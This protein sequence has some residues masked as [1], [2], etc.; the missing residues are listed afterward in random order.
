M[1]KFFSAVVALLLC[2]SP[3]FS[4][5]IGGQTTVPLYK[6]ARLWAVDLP[7]KSVCFWGISPKAS[8]DVIKEIKGKL[9]FTG[10]A[11]DYTVTLSAVWIDTE[12]NLASE[13]AEDVT[14]TIGGVGPTPPGPP[15]P[16]TPP[17]DPLYPSLLTA[18]AAETDTAKATSAGQ[19]AALYRAAAALDTSSLKTLG[20]LLKA[21]KA[22]P[23]A[24]A[25]KGKLPGVDR[26]VANELNV[27]LG[28]V[29]TTPLDDALN[30]KAKG[31]FT[32]MAALMDALAKSKK[33]PRVKK[34]APKKKPKPPDE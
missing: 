19:F 29:A 9:Y 33:L 23:E 30:A 4:L 5:S 20:D 13:D 17:N 8:A 18:Y 26:V 1:K 34:S 31:Q 28:K 22:T 32:R 27:Q 10:P 7:T 16:P 25:I 14:V 3:A 21:I 2:T 15:V 6:I 24:A 11:G 12:G